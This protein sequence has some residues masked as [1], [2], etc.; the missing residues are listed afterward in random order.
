MARK[1]KEAEQVDQVEQNDAKDEGGK[2][3]TS[4]RARQLQMGK[5]DQ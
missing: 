5:R 1:K 4:E 3:D 2:P